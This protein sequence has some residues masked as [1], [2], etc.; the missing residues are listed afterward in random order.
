MDKCGTCIHY[1][2]AG[3]WDLCCMK[4]MRRLTYGYYDACEKYEPNPIKHRYYVVM[5]GQVIA[6]HND[7]IGIHP[8]YAIS[9]M[10]QELSEM[11]EKADKEEWIDALN[12][13]RKEMEEE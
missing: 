1:T 10:G 4:S 6:M 9:L 13:A 11:M 12:E 2:G 5:D 8:V 7:K 3:D